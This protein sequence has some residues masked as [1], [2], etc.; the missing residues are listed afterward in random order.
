[1]SNCI[2]PSTFDEII[3]QENVKQRLR[4]CVEGCKKTNSVMP[5][6]LIDGPPGLGKTTIASAIANE[7]GVNL[8]TTNA[9]TIRNPKNILVYIMGIAPRSVLFI[10][11]IHRLPKIVEEFLYP[12]MEDFVLNITTKDKDDKDKPETIDLPLFTIVGATTSGGSLSQPFYDRFTIKE[13]LSFYNENELAKLARLNLKK[14]GVVI[15]DES[16]LEI[17]KRSKGTPRILN[18][19]LQWYKNYMTCNENK[20]ISVDEIFEVQG[21]DKNGL[22]MYDRMYLDI[23]KKSK[24]NALG[25][26]T[27]SSMTGIAIDTIE[28]SIE[29]FL[30]RKG[31][32][33]R[34]PKGRVLA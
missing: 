9:A 27:I 11:E 18:A 16:L 25:L 6:V 2:R 13:H 28:N 32:V 17:A 5:H 19:R 31:Y 7:M 12:V 22:D 30:I 1:M 34:T 14:M 3:G 21:I 20:K 33:I 23:L 29:P 24:G 10:D 26:K 15:D 8:Y 4:V